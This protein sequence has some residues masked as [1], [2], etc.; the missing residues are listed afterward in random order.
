MKAGV[1]TVPPR[2]HPATHQKTAVPHL[3]VVLLLQLLQQ[4]QDLAQLQGGKDVEK[5]IPRP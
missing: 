3:P 1:E 4:R 2:A 5:R